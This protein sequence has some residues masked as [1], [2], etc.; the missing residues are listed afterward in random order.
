MSQKVGGWNW[1]NYSM[2]CHDMGS[3]EGN[4]FQVIVTISKSIF[5]WY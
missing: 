3:W 1:V 2:S 4:E 5:V